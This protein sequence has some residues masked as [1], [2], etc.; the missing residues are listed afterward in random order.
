MSK[1]GVGV[2]EDFPVDENN[3]PE[4]DV[5]DLG[6]CHHRHHGRKEAW[7]RFRHQMHQEW[8]ARRRAFRDRLNEREGVEAIHEFREHHLHHL[9]VGGLAVLGLAALIAG[10]SRRD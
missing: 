10:L 8:H 7:R 9:I 5:E 1:I 2:G 4:P 6:T 3:K